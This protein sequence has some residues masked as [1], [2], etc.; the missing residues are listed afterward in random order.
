MTTILSCLRL[1]V[2]WHFF[3]QGLAKLLAPTWTAAPYLLL[4]RG[5]FSGLFH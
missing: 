2:G 3:Y 5:I 1:A 4:S